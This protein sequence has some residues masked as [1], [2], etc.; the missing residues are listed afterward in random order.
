MDHQSYYM[1]TVADVPEA[2]KGTNND[3][4]KQ[5]SA[6]A[7]YCIADARRA[8]ASANLLQD[9]ADRAECKAKAGLECSPEE[10]QA[11]EGAQV[12][13]EHAQAAAAR[14]IAAHKAVAQVKNRCMSQAVE[15]AGRTDP[16]LVAAVQLAQVG[17]ESEQV[18]PEALGK[19]A[20]GSY[21]LY[22]SVVEATVFQELLRA[23]KPLDP[24]EFPCLQALLQESIIKSQSAGLGADKG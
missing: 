14:A 21:E 24:H 23:Q 1:A 11:A 16:A 18:Y 4:L 12:A 3:E 17:L 5:A 20:D 15:A 9:L 6:N 10:Q 22:A 8:S 13:A 19:E 2:L 7:A